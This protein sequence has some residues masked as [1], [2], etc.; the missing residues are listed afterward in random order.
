VQDAQAAESSWHSKL[1]PGSLAE[2]ANDALVVAV[3]PLGPESMVV[4]GGVL[5]D[6]G[7]IV[8]D[9]VAGDASVLPAGSVA[10]TLKVCDPVARP[11]YVFGLVHDA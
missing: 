3:E 6:A 7:V 2:K 5:S 4:S 9:C 8:H 10:R 11:L 1:A